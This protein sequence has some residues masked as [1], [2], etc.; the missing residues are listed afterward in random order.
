MQCDVLTL[1]P[2]LI[3]GIAAQSMLKRAQES[4]RVCIRSHNIRDYIKDRHRIADDAP[5]GG[6]CG[7]VMKAEP[8]FRAIDA[9]QDEGQELRLI[10]P[11][12]QG[13]PFSH[14]LA[15]D[16][17]RES[18]RLVWICGHY[19][20]ID[21]RVLTR[22]EPEEISIGDY[23]LTG[24]ELPAMVMIDAAARL[25]PGVVG[26]PGSVEQDSFADVLLDYPHYT[27]PEGVRGYGVPDVLL[28]GNHAAIRLWRRKESLR[29]TYWKRP[30][31]LH[32]ECLTEEDRRLLREISQE[33]EQV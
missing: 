7:M 16:L 27:R 31:V 5:Y 8:I 25:V 9:L 2:E 1:F 29:N 26:D 30:D 18:R 14:Q 20:G 6:G 28:S 24:G 15:M 11:S 19:E 4:G 21:E 17:S 13:I 33:C 22:L 3:E 10:F 12:P 23:V 32:D